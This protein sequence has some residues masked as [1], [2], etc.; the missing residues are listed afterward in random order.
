MYF[1]NTDVVKMGETSDLEV[2]PIVRAAGKLSNQ[3]SRRSYLNT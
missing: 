2:R 3:M 1:Q